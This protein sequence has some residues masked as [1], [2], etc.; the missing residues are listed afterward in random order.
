M[1][2]FILPS[3]L[4]DNPHITVGWGNG[5]VIIP[6]GHPLH[7]INYNEICD[8][9]DYNV[10]GG[11]TFGR[12]GVDLDAFPYSISEEDKTGWVVG[13]DTAHLDDNL[14]TCS[15]EYVE[16]ETENLK[17]ALENYNK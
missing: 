14:I 10:H 5:Y 7:G 11:L 8:A 13:F 17:I 9:I 4:A 15:K 2:T 3:P 16:Q 6:E 1:K 12:P